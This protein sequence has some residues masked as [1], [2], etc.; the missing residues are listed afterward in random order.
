M[1]FVKT[2]MS[3]RLGPFGVDV[4][5]DKVLIGGVVS[6]EDPVITVWIP[7]GWAPSWLLGRNRTA[8][9]ADVAHFGFDS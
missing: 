8:K 3:G 6:K 7:F 2:F 4:V 5:V 9:R 1:K